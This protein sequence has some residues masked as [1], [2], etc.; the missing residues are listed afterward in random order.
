MAAEA[1]RVADGDADIGLPGRLGHVIEVTL[2]SR[3]VE[4]DCR[5]DNSGFDSLCADNGL[6]A[7]RGS[8]QMAGH[9]LG[10]ADGH[11]H[12]VVTESKFDGPCLGEIA[13]RRASAMGIGVVNV[14]SIDGCVLE[15]SLDG[16]RGS[17][18]L[19]I[20]CGDVVAVGGLTIAEQFGIDL[21]A[22]SDG[23]LKFFEDDNASA[24]GKNESIAIG[25]E[26]SRSSRWVVVSLG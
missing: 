1:K 2:S 11:L 26:G 4:I 7:A 17:Y 13:K 22:S 15:S 20:R 16:E 23:M 5:R 25:I 24:L 9:A 14:V 10:G 12:G 6:H 8:E 21:S 18:A 19:F 3:I